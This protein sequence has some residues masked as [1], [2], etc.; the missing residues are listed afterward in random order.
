MYQSEEPRSFRCVSHKEMNSYADGPKISD[1]L[2]KTTDAW[3]SFEYF[4]PKT[5]EGVECLKQKIQRMKNYGPMYA[6]ITSGLGAS[7]SEA[8]LKLANLTQNELGC[9][10]NMHLGCTSQKTHAADETLTAC[11]KIGVRN[12]VALHGDPPHGQKQWP[13]SESGSPDALNLIKLM[14]DNYGDHFCIS[15]AGYP[16]GHPDTITVVDG[17]LSELSPKEARRA[18]VSPEG[19]VTVC[20]DKDFEKGM[21]FLKE[22]C[23]AGA[24]IVITQMFLDTQV[25]TDF[26]EA[27]RE[28]DIGV[29][30]VPGIMCLSNLRSF[31][32]ITNLYKTR[33]PAGVFEAARAANVSDEAFK[34]W[35]IQQ[36]TQMCKTC[37]DGGAPGLHFYTLNREKVVTD[38][39][40]NLGFIGAEQVQGDIEGEDNAKLLEPAEGI[41]TMDT[42]TE[43]ALT[44]PHIEKHHSM[45]AD[46]MF[47]ELERLRAENEQLKQETPSLDRKALQ[48][49]SSVQM[50]ELSAQ[51]SNWSAQTRDDSSS[52]K[53]LGSWGSHAKSDRLGDSVGC[54]VE[55]K[56]G[57]RYWEA[58]LLS[59]RSTD[60]TVK[61]TYDGSET[62]CENHNIRVKDTDNRYNDEKWGWHSRSQEDGLY[63]FVGSSV[64][65]KYGDKF[66]DA[67]MISAGPTTCIV[68][69][70]YDGS[71][72]ECDNDDVRVASESGR[73]Q[74]EPEGESDWTKH[75]SRYRK[76][77]ESATTLAFDVGSTVEAKYG[78]KFLDATVVSTGPSTSTVKWFYD[79]SQ[80]ECD[81]LEIRLK[82]AGRWRDPRHEQER[83]EASTTSPALVTGSAVEAK[84]GDRFF[85]AK[86][87]SPGPTWSLVKWSYDD[88]ES[89]CANHTIR[90]LDNM[91]TDVNEDSNGNRVPGSAGWSTKV[92]WAVETMATNITIAG[93]VLSHSV[94]CVS[95]PTRGGSM[96]QLYK[97][98]CKGDDAVAEIVAWGD[99]ALKLEAAC[100]RS[101]VDAGSFAVIG[102]VGATG[103]GAVFEVKS[104]DLCVEYHGR[105]WAP[106]RMPTET[107]EAAAKESHKS[108]VHIGGWVHEVNKPT[109]TAG[110]NGTV[111]SRRA[112]TFTSVLG[113]VTSIVFWGNAAQ[114]E[115]QEG[116]WYDIA[117]AQVDRERKCFEVNDDSGVS[118]STVSAEP[119]RKRRRLRWDGN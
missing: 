64:E 116:V 47:A 26:I 70:A 31:E 59:V 76:F 63:A 21:A 28:Q 77:P 72:T 44:V 68:Q 87:V 53:H 105:A 61:W 69:W 117:A 20:R 110:A 33:L 99:R 81:N 55:V 79:G 54:V 90:S 89:Q 84:Y 66:M 103:E 29:P 119:P 42:D 112:C 45:D 34:T 39:L 96:V 48:Q 100:S 40:V 74:H 83:P 71:Q 62:T 97:V 92:M 108:R 106:S 25:Y 94:S 75:E 11:K 2:V 111:R 102:P 80:T 60:S 114:V 16:E 113:N 5:P 49:E 118:T 23:D 8:T 6:A 93:E 15:V 9:V 7:T 82:G 3:F 98:W 27:C 91:I 30:V 38:I 95:V 52:D 51:Q 58:V 85:E 115:V 86:V 12:I 78:E 50:C 10:T 107:L 18:R 41:V 37:L 67:K 46:T 109:H 73:F 57:K 43:G 104:D 35:S 22:H 19:V 36:S 13:A 56:Y 24:D 1:L 88:S 17:G 101:S 65:A 4:P 14:R 32:R